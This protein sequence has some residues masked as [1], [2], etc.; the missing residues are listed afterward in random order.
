M[1]SSWR[2]NELWLAVALRTGLCFD[3]LEEPINWLSQWMF[4]AQGA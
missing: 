2:Q 3:C 1:E 4:I